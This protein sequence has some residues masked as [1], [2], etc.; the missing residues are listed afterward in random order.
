MIRVPAWGVSDCYKEAP[1][2]P[3]K[4][5]TEGLQ[6]VEGTSKHQ[7]NQAHQEQQQLQSIEGRGQDVQQQ[8]HFRELADELELPHHGDQ[9]LDECFGSGCPPFY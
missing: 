2:N 7:H 4:G 8:L 1:R 9:A 5:A 6:D 3:Q